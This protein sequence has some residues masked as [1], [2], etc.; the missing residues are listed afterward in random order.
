[1]GGTEY[2]KIWS[3]YK[4]ATQEPARGKL[5][6]GLWSRPEFDVL[7]DL[8]WKWTEKVNG[9][10]VRII[11]DGHKVDIGG[12]TDDAQMPLILVRLLRNMFTEEM[13]ETQF[14]DAK[15]TLYGEGYGAKVSAGSGVYS[16]DPS[17]IMFDANVAG[18]WLE[19]SSLD[20]LGAQMGIPVVPPV[21][22]GSID[23][24][25]GLVRDRQFRSAWGNFQPEGLVGKPPL[26]LMGRDGDRLL[27]KLKAKDFA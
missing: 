25:I 19:P 22:T 12:R 5:I 14:H 9:T 16:P 7:S 6:E 17:F 1:M 26:G 4:R 2:H 21:L 20:E 3:P 10:N 13:L 8:D 24:A 18:W 11:W 15:V 23:E 27:I